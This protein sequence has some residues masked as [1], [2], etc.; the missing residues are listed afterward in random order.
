MKKQFAYIFFLGLLLLVSAGNGIAQEK[1]K[2]EEITDK[3]KWLTIEQADSLNKLHPKPFLID[4]YTDWC[5]WC[6]YMSKTT[7][8][9]P[10][11]AGYINERFYPVKFNA[12]GNDTIHFAGKEYVN[13]GIGRR[14]D[15]DFA[16][17]FMEHK[18][19]FPTT[20]FMTAD[21]KI[22]IRIPGYLDVPKIEP[23]LI[24]MVEYVYGTTPVND[25]RNDW[26]RAFH[27]STNT[28]TVKWYDIN[29]A[30]K[31]SKTKH[32]PILA[33]VNTS[34]CSSCQVMK[35][36]V[37]S[38]SVIYDYV[39]THFL[40]VDLDPQTTEPITFQNHL[41]TKQ[42]NQPFHSFVQTIE[43]KRVMLPSIIFIDGYEN[44]LS[45]V[46]YY[47]TAFDLEPLIHFF[48]DAA[49]KTQKWQPYVKS[50][51]HNVSIKTK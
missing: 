34:W 35:K 14:P 12:E 17:E 15:H 42:A 10:Q 13:K 32:K 23:F 41:F 2:T 21:Y 33:F 1:E 5:G 48:G 11:I 37:F 46:P 38:D 31:I 18:M 24:Y 26:T 43:K 27:D 7:Y 50:F 40:L 8:S 44:T 28:D 6:K 25:F 3:V 19:S 39:K 20:L 4:F 22:K 51:H 9:N 45:S 47:H 49:Y 36:A 29:T 30:L 16:L